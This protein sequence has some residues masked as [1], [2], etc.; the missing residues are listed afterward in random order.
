MLLTFKSNDNLNEYNFDNWPPPSRISQYQDV[1]APYPG[2]RCPPY[3]QYAGIRHLPYSNGPLQLAFQRPKKECRTFQSPAV[4]KVIEEVTSRMKDND[5]ARMFENCFPNTLDTTIRWYVLGD[6]PKAFITTGDINAQWLRDSANQLQPYIDLLHY[7]ENLR[8]L[9][10]G[11]IR[12]QA[13]YIISSPYCNAFN[14]PPE[15]NI[16]PA[17]SGYADRVYPPPNRKVVFECKYE[18]DS[19]ASFLDLSNEYYTATRD[20]K[21]MDDAWIRAI[22]S[23]FDV[24]RDQQMPTFTSDNSPNF[25]EYLF[26]RTTTLAT[27]TLALNGIGYPVN[28]GT[29]LIKSSFR[30]SDDSTILPFLIPVNAMMA[31][32]LE[33]IS[34]LLSKIGKNELA[35]FAQ[36]TSNSVRKGIEEHAIF[37]H[38]VFGKI[39][40]YEVDGYGGRIIMDDA[41]IPSLLSL[42]RLGFLKKEDQVYQNTRKAILSKTGNPYYLQG[43][44]FKGIGGP[45]VGL[46]NAWPMSLLQ[47]ISTTDND[48]EILELLNFIKES[49]YGLGLIHESVNVNNL[50][51]FT[52]SWFSWANS[53]F[54]RVILDLAKRKPLLI[55]KDGNNPFYLSSIFEHK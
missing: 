11:A 6:D 32:Q 27:E 16:P 31:V 2:A 12:M 55:F 37:E 52:R 44:V 17:G 8:K 3:S 22:E 9:V 14:A 15:S 53:E 4:E 35:T 30:P 23:I 50:G 10:L 38:P 28:T 39:F 51:M 5:L 29:S 25:P 33:K 36:E 47:Q 24:I 34:Q 46:R 19:L 13:D 40:A 21:F 42:P 41:N 54:A 18:L 1:S 48:N 26:E 45:H 49:T 20:T 43:S 7:D